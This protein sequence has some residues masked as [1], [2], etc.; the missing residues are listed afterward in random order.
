MTKAAAFQFAT[1]SRPLVAASPSALHLGSCQHFVAAAAVEIIK[2]DRVKI[3][4]EGLSSYG[5]MSALLM[6]SCLRL[7][8]STPKNLTKLEGRYI[9]VA[10]IIFMV[11][12]VSSIVCGCYTTVVFSL[13]GLYAKTA[14]GLSQ[15]Q[16]FLDF[17]AATGNVRK[18]AFNAL[19]ISLV[20]FEASFVT[21]LFISYDEKLRWWA[22][23][24]ATACV[25]ISFWHWSTILLTANRLLFTGS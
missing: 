15:D 18:W 20:S 24:I 25:V 4:L 8:S 22:A 1:A 19:L 16:P 14:L 23:G 21:S 3:R 9:T 11:S 13:L 10:K 12:I 17:F 7:F 6:N 2:I 5:V